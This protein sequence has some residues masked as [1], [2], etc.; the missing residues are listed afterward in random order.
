MLQ[1]SF[2]YAC[3]LG[4]V[5]LNIIWLNQRGHACSVAESGMLGISAQL[6]LIYF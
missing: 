5:K 4:I 6:R 2:E 3:V 1:T